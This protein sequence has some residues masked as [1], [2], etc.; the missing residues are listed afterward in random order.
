MPP[1]SKASPPGEHPPAGA[2]P[3]PSRAELKRAERRKAILEAAGACF[4]RDGFHGTSMQKIC[5]EARMSPGALYRYFPSKEA[6]IAAIVQDQR[7]EWLKL[8]HDIH[9]Q[10]NI[11]SA[12][13]D[14]LT[15][16]LSDPDVNTACLGPEIMAEAIR[17]TALRQ[18]LADEEELTR[19]L[20][21]DALATAVTRGEIDPAI[22]LED[23]V[24]LLQI[25]ADGAVLHHLL[26]PEWK[27]PERLPAYARLTSRMLAPPGTP[28]PGEKA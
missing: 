5:A 3:A 23:I 15:L 28:D 17:N 24:I 12:L 22:P 25:M 18:T 20:L 19:G 6:I 16:M 11:I 27:L 13:T 1:H 9:E 10:P 4:A 26:H 7:T 2:P 8:F 21:S 14:T